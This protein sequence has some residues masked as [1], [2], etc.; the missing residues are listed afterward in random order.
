MRVNLPVWTDAARVPIGHGPEQTSRPAPA[1]VVLPR[2]RGAGPQGR[3]RTR[4]GGRA[5]HGRAGARGRQRDPAVGEG[6]AGPDHLG[7]D[8][9]CPPGSP[10]ARPSRPGRRPGSPPPCSARRCCPR[11]RPTTGSGR[12]ATRTSARRRLVHFAK[13]L[14]LAGGLLI[15]S[16]DTAGKPGVAWRAKHAAH[17]AK[18]EAALLGTRAKARIS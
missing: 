11:L 6:P 17:D 10:P 16:L 5:R 13:N 1:G 2:Q 4:Q 15:A 9:R 18:R 8:Q 3:P 12:R 14:S 7:A